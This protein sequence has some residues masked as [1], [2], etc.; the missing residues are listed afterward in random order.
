MIP[1]KTKGRSPKSQ[2]GVPGC[3]DRSEEFLGLQATGS[4]HRHHLWSPGK[5]DRAGAGVSF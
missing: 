1:F 4:A 2:Q 3:S 5:Q